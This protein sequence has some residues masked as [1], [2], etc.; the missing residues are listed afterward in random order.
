MKRPTFAQAMSPLIVLVLLLAI[1]YGQMRLPMQV[2]LLFSTA[3]TS[4]LAL[5]LGYSWKEIASGIE[6]KIASSL[7]SL[8][9]LLCVGGMIAAW[10]ASGT[11][12]MMIYYGIKLINPQFIFITSF[13]VC[14][15]ISSFTGT[16]FG[17]AATAGVVCMGT[18]IALGVPLEICAGAVI[19][20]AIFGDKLSPFS[21]T[22]IL[23]TISSGSELYAHIKH[24]LF[25]TGA[26]TILCLIIFTFIGF[27]YEVRQDY[28]PKSVKL[29]LSNLELL[30]NFNILLLLPPILIFWGAYTK[31][32]TVPMIMFSSLVAIMLSLGF[33]GITLQAVMKAFVAG[34]KV[35]I[36]SSAQGVEVIKPVLKLL[37]RGGMESMLG[38]VLQVMCAFSFAGVYSKIGCI[39]VVLEKV[40]SSIKSV[41]HL[42]TAT[43]SST[44]VLSA[45]TGSC[46]LSMLVCGDMFRQVYP[47]FNL[48]QENLSRSLEDAG[49][50]V[51]PLFPWSI[52]G[53]YMASTLG[54]PTLDYLPWAV[55][56]YSGMVFAIIFGFT[57]FGISKTENKL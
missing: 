39:Q 28:D 46:Y 38:T 34:F 55:L 20:G 3:F 7:P 45:V 23:A 4:L 32:P 49:T 9:I 43:I 40:V 36:L 22:T 8:I 29:I 14:A 47:K 42:I 2:M 56:C 31:K 35:N 16:S 17:S 27:N 24:M 19:S 18:A 30:Y 1:G 26:S 25:T 5:K 54:V 57:G 13:L 15:I 33:Q 51:V 11:I 52:T 41:G 10:M 44:F 37:N 12:P 48:K 53:G 50:C 6:E 21:D